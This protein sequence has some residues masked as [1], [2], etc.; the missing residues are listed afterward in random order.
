[1]HEFEFALLNLILFWSLQ[2]NVFSISI[3]L[4][5]GWSDKKFLNLS[6]WES[7]SCQHQSSLPKQPCILH[8]LKLLSGALSYTVAL[9]IKTNACS[10][11]TSPFF[12][13]LHSSFLQGLS[14]FLFSLLRSCNKKRAGGQQGINN[15]QSR[16]YNHSSLSTALSLNST[17]KHGVVIHVSCYLKIHF[18]HPNPQKEI[19]KT[20]LMLH[21]CEDSELITLKYDPY[22]KRTS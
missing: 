2:S 12:Y 5:I 15:I 20:K 3:I 4:G 19:Y 8:A 17:L 9:E 6:G 7:L 1:M 16:L 22:A 13:F 11:S 10:P 14:F 18:K 21:L